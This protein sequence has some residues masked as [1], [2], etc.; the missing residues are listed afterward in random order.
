M[1]RLFH[2]ALAV[3]VEHVK[4]HEG[5]ISADASALLE[6]GLNALMA[7]AR[8]CLAVEDGG[9]KGPRDLVE[10]RHTGVAQEIKPSPAETGRF[11]VLDVELGPLTV[12]LG[13][14][15]V[16]PISL[17]PGIGEPL[18]EHGRDERCHGT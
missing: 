1:P 18:A 3:Q 6:Y 7:V 13:L 12:E 14:S 5:H 11:T 15:D 16:V 9:V 8:A 17:T 4:E 10:P 2:D